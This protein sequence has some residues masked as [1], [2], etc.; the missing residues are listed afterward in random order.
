MSLHNEI[1]QILNLSETES[2]D[3]L[4]IRYILTVI[5]GKQI[6]FPSYSH[7]CTHQKLTRLSVCL[8]YSRSEGKIE[9]REKPGAIVQRILTNG[10]YRIRKDVYYSVIS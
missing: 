10:L 5:E 4:P 7:C 1:A 9:K 8:N 2:I 3:Y 6:Y